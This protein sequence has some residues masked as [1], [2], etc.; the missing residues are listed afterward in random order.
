MTLGHWRPKPFASAD[1]QPSTADDPHGQSPRGTLSSIL[2]LGWLW[3]N[4]WVAWLWYLR[5]ASTAGYVIFDRYHGDLL[6]DP[7]RYRYGGPGWLSRLWS[8]LLPQPDHVLFLDAE[9]EILI[10]RKQEVS[11]ES[12]EQSRAGYAH[13]I[14]GLSRGVVV[15]ASGSVEQVVSDVRALIG[16]CMKNGR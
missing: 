11:L 7:R 1:T 5:G 15:D 14:E 16:D 4:W 13:L 3:F 6:V 12:L 2:K 8:R 9:P 10:A